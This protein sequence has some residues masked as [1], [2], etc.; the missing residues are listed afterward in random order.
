MKNYFIKNFDISTDIE[1]YD[2]EIG[3]ILNVKIT[4]N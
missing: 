4:T 3:H 2:R 1:V